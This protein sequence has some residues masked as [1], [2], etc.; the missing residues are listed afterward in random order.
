M[1]STYSQDKSYQF[2]LQFATILIWSFGREGLGCAVWPSTYEGVG[3][4]MQGYGAI[5]VDG[6]DVNW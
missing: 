1:M 2:L 3:S 5:C 6:A 4:A